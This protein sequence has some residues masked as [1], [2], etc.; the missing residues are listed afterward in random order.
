VIGLSFTS[1]W[2]RK[3]HKIFYPITERS[4]AK[5]KQHANYFQH[6]IENHSISHGGENSKYNHRKKLLVFAFSFSSNKIFTE[7]VDCL[8]I[9]LCMQSVDYT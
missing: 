2:L 3:W 8:Q 7:V 1:D 5:P 4:N 9:T 6:S